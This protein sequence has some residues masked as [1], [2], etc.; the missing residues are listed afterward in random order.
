M[1]EHTGIYYLNMR[2]FTCKPGSRGIVKPLVWR[3]RKRNSAY[4]RKIKTG[5]TP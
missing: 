1:Q 2:M 3:D 5:Q 4:N